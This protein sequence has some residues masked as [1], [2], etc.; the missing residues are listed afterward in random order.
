VPFKVTG[1][2]G[3]TYWFTVSDLRCVEGADAGARPA[4][5]SGGGGC[6]GQ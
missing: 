5:P 3:D 1:P 2:R 4:A 6:R